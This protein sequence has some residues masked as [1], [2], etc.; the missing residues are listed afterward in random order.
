MEWSEEMNFSKRL[1]LIPILFPYVFLISISFLNQQQKSKVILLTWEIPKMTIGNYIAISSTVGFASTFSI[2]LLTSYKRY[3]YNRKVKI[4]QYEGI[5]TSNTYD[6]RYGNQEGQAIKDYKNEQSATVYIE[7]DLKQ[8]YPTITVPFKVKESI[9]LNQGSYSRDDLQNTAEEAR[10]KE[11]SY[12]TMSD[13][14]LNQTDKSSE[15]DWYLEQ[16]D[17]W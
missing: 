5:N 14:G 7:R 16:Y 1:L 6:D 11:S 3:T 12:E 4:N 10:E 9:N 2:Y 8:P 13:Y 17:N 15:D